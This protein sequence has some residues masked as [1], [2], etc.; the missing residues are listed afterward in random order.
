MIFSCQKIFII[1]S[2]QLYVLLISLF[3]I[4]CSNDLEID[5]DTDPVPVCYCL[6]DL[7]S[8]NQYVRIGQTFRLQNGIADL[9]N[10]FYPEWNIDG[11]VKVYIEKIEIAEPVEQYDFYL[12]EGFERD[13]G[14]FP[15]EDV[16]IYEANFKPQPETLYK[17]YI[18]LPDQQ[19][20]IFGETKTICKSRIIDPSPI[21]GRKIVFDDYSQYIS[22]F[23]PG[24]NSS[25]FY[26]T[27]HLSINDMQIDYDIGNQI[28]FSGLPQLHRIYSGSKYVNYIKSMAGLISSSDK[29]HCSYSLISGSEE[30]ALYISAG[31]NNGA[32][33]V[34]PL[35]GYTNLTNAQGVFGSIERTRV[36]NLSLHELSIKALTENSSG[37]DNLITGK[38]TFN[39][40]TDQIQGVKQERIHRIDLSIAEDFENLYKKN[41]LR[42]A[43]T[44]DTK[45][46]YSYDLSP[47]KYTYQAGITCSAKGDSCLWGG[48]PGGRFG[49]I[50]TSDQFEIIKDSTI[51]I[52]LNFM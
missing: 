48:F 20:M 29:L 35:N 52:N 15:M 34:G 40:V 11:A 2:R 1:R 6:L 37:S 36:S 27:F 18:W 30:L 51:V 38:V 16:V 19:N 46:Q 9:D 3:V 28:D 13:S 21:S 47:G 8:Y 12:R 32:S 50:W 17:L 49:S 45:S 24:K 10:D 42:A 41:F 23:E 39:F 25:V 44:S 22:V 5:M 43:N 26:G 7:D 14:L 33:F 4:G 31:E